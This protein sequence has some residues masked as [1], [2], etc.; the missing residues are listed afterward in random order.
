MADFNDINPICEGMLEVKD[1]NNAIEQFHNYMNSK[2]V[3]LRNSF[4]ISPTNI[5]RNLLAEIDNPIQA[6]VSGCFSR[7]GYDRCYS[8]FIT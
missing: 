4:N 6:H 2:N 1:D 7:N 3:S 8:Q 5:V